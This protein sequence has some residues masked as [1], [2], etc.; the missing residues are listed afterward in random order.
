MSYDLAG[1]DDWERH[2]VD[3]AE[4]ASDNPAASPSPEAVRARTS[5]SATTPPNTFKE[6]DRNPRRS[7]A[8]RSKP[9]DRTADATAAR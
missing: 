1:G 2:W 6:P 3:Y 7:M 4:S 8:T 9:L 5:G